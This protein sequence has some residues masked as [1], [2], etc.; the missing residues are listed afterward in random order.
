[1]LRQPG[2]AARHWQMP[3]RYW[4]GSA[5]RRRKTWLRYIE[6]NDDLFTV[7]L[8]M[9]T[10]L[11]PLSTD[12][13]IAGLPLMTGDFGVGTSMIQLTLTLSMA[14][15]AIGQICIGPISDDVGRKTPMLAGMAVFTASS[16]GCVFATSIYAF[17]HFDS[18][19]AF[20][21][22]PASSLPVP[23]PAILVAARH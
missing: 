4:T 10:A 22:V 7:F 5:G 6:K 17:W 14:G 12:M 11:A 15:M 20:L 16:V 3:F 21:V 23:L 1:M 19:R 2:I 18:S 8:G 13:Y 9:M